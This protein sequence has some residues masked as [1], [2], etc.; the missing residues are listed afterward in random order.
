M[1][2]HL[3]EP[4]PLP[5]LLDV[6]FTFHPNQGKP[7]SNL[8]KVVSLVITAD[9]GASISSPLLSF[10]SPLRRACEFWKLLRAV[11]RRG[12]RNH[13]VHACPPNLFLV[14]QILFLDHNSG[15]KKKNPEWCPQFRIRKVNLS[16]FCFLRY[17]KII[18]GE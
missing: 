7:Q 12:W 16:L 13:R 5:E 3:T 18:K 14:H 10:P 11:W 15:R 6:N 2:I 8:A 9:L 1:L 4:S 17:N